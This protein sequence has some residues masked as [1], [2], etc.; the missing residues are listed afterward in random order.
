MNRHTIA[1]KCIAFSLVS[2]ASASY[3]ACPSKTI[4]SCT[5]TKGKAVEVCESPKTI[6]YSFGKKGAKPEMA[7]SVP[8]SAASTR[9]W[10]GIGRNM[11]YSVLIPNGKATYEVFSNVD[12][13]DEET[14][15]G[16]YVV[17]GGKELA[18]I[19]CK[20]NTVTDNISD[21][22]LKDAPEE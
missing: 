12:K 4:F 17:V 5:T 19:S 10:N 11:Y 6:D 16:I 3:A 18:T 1:A 8:R 7:L 14:S 15:Y 2:Y 21:V 20:P 9:R 13:F 22:T